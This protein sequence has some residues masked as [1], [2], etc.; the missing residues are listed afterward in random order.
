M[1]LSLL[2]HEFIGHDGIYENME[3]DESENLDEILD[4]EKEVLESIY[5]D[6]VLYQCTPAG[7]RFSIE[8]ES[9]SVSICI[10]ANHEY[11]YKVPGIV[12]SSSKHPAYIRLAL[13]QKIMMDAVSNFVG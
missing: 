10:P 1:A 8:L 13:L 12:L 6:A 9:I 7:V 5:N 2:C 11:P 3:L 4:Q